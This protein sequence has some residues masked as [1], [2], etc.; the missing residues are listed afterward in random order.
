MCGI[1]GLVSFGGRRIDPDVLHA[2]NEAL[3]HRGPDSRG[4]FV[5]GP[6]GLAARRLAIIDLDGGDQPIA[7]EDG[8]VHVVQNGEIYNH[9]ELRAELEQRGHRFKT[10]HSDTEVLVH[11]YEEWGDGLPVRLNGMFAFVVWDRTR[12]RLFAARDRFGEKPFYYSS[13][14]GS[15]VFGS[16]LS[17]L[18]R[19]PRVDRTLE[20]RSLQKFFAYGYLP[21]PNTIFRRARKLPGGCHLTVDLAAQTVVETRYWR[22]CI[23][24]ED[25]APASRDGALAEELRALIDRA[26]DRRLVSDV[27]LGV[28]LSGGVDSSAIL[29][30]AARHRSAASLDTFTIGFD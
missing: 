18:T 5:D 30:F 6:V 21:A 28:F 4:A 13:Q 24:A 20:Q 23:E 26:V 14:P 29:G 2:M 22:F 10:D 19:H 11:G 25:D 27:P 3:M 16:E 12:R 1:C 15:F 8:S 9:A 7:N 17:V